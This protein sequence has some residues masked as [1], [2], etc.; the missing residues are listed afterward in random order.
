[1]E[2]FYQPFRY[3]TPLKQ[4][5]STAIMQFPYS[6]TTNSSHP[7]ISHPSVKRFGRLRVQF[8]N[9]FE[10]SETASEKPV[11]SVCAASGT[12]AAV[13]GTRNSFRCSSLGTKT[14]LRDGSAAFPRSAAL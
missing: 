1:M 8:L 2:D 13:T 11:D 14:S 5:F 3:E 10:R 7:G 12:N 9:Y 4:S 6:P